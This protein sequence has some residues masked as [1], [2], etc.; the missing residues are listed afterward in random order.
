MGNSRPCHLSPLC[1]Q[2][3]Q[4]TSGALEGNFASIRKPGDAFVP[5]L[6]L[7]MVHD[8]TYHH[9]MTDQLASSLQGSGGNDTR[10]TVAAG[11]R[12]DTL[13]QWSKC[14]ISENNHSVLLRWGKKRAQHSSCRTLITTLKHA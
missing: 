4:K 1:R 5:I 11:A 6:V 2:A 10:S 12:V 9:S 13:F 14:N 8:C 7:R 3:Y